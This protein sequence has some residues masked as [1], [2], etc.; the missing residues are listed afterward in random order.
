MFNV[1]L[2]EQF[3]GR[4]EEIRHGGPSTNK[5]TTQIP[6]APGAGLMPKALGDLH[7]SASPIDQ[8]FAKWLCPSALANGR[9]IEKH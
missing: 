2:L 5:K 4:S 6:H 7:F 3:T 8:D 1:S 9:P